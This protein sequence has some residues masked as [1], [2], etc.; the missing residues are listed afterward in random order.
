[1]AFLDAVDGTGQPGRPR[2]TEGVIGYI[3]RPDRWRQG[4]ATTIVPELLRA[5]FESLGLRRIT[6]ACTAANIASVRALEHAGMR[7][8][9]HGI[10]D[11]WHTE[12]GW[13]DS[14][15]YALLAEEWRIR[16]R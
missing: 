13:V 4:I 16:D 15:G 11:E 1:M 12:L 6:A 3:V 7:R 14:F 10:A 2:G 9:R 5:G 8:E